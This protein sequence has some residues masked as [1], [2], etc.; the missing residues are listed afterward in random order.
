M[1]VQVVDSFPPGGPFR[2]GQP[3]P[4]GRPFPP[5]APPRHGRPPDRPL[6]PGEPGTP[7]PGWRPTLPGFPAGAPSRGWIDTSDWPGK[8]YQRLLEQRIVLASGCLDAEAATVLSAQ[9]LTLD[10]E[11][12]GPVRL[13][14]QGLDAE[15]PAALTVMGVLDVVRVPVT[16]YVAGRISGPALGVLAACSRRRAY[17]NAVFA[18]AEPRMNLDGTATEVSGQEEQVR[19]ML[20]SLYLR[21][22]ETTGR[23]VDD[24]RADARLGRFFTVAQAIDYGLIEEQAEGRGQGQGPH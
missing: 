11:G 12:D 2:P 19:A 6:R 9:L 24:I 16:G 15:L 18:L 17:P 1:R 3:Y 7:G 5:G 20:D 14:L 22:A 8:L 10:A 21:L 23:E 4:P 13:E